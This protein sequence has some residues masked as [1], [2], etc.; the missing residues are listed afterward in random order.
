MFKQLRDLPLISIFFCSQK[1]IE[2]DC[3]ENR[4]RIGGPGRGGLAG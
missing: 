3:T 2:Y 1:L 4:A